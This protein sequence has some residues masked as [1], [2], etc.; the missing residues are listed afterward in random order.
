M[1]F[2]VKEHN[3]FTGG[4]WLAVPSGLCSRA[5]ADI[6]QFR[7]AAIVKIADVFRK[8]MEFFVGLHGNFNSFSE[9]NV[10]PY[11]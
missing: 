11:S 5:P 10:S 7:N 4:A 8:G 9:R 1:L 6:V 2:C 3:D